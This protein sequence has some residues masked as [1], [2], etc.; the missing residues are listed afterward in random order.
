MICDRFEARIGG[1]HPQD[2]TCA[3]Q[4]RQR[5]T[6]ALGTTAEDVTAFDEDVHGNP[7]S[8][9]ASVKTRR[10]MRQRWGEDRALRAHYAAMY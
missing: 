4:K 3:G 6:A 9:T 7:P 2:S 10:Q 1:L 5:D 8:L